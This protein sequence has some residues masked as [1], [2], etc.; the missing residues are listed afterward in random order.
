MFLYF[1]SVKSSKNGRGSNRYFQRSNLNHIEEV[2]K[3][4]MVGQ[5]WISLS[6]LEGCLW[7]KIFK[8]VR[9]I[10]ARQNKIICHKNYQMTS[11]KH[12][13]HESLVICVQKTFCQ[14]H[15]NFQCYRLKCFQSYCSRDTDNP[16][17]YVLQ[18]YCS[19]VK[20]RDNGS[21]KTAPIKLIRLSKIV[22][23]IK[24]SE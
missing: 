8:N 19:L 16:I 22:C 9:M 11:G 10:L 24:H 17:N 21:I 2:E 23:G 13:I 12:I 15:L 7:E 18:K 4:K 20:V 5:F 6:L 1:I 3:G 14:N